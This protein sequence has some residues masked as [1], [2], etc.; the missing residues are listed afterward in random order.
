MDNI[1]PSYLLFSFC[2]GSM[3]LFFLIFYVQTMC[4]SQNTRQ[5]INFWR[6]FQRMLFS[7]YMHNTSEISSF[8]QILTESYNFL[9]FALIVFPDL[10][11][12]P[13]KEHPLRIHY[14]SYIMEDFFFSC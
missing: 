12:I 14:E 9:K 2:V 7:K 5:S 3:L 1:A 6:H 4:D 8:D 10:D 11:I 13:I